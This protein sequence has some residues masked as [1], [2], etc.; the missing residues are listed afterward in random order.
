MEFLT[1]DILDSSWNK[2]YAEYIIRWNA[3]AI[4]YNDISS[5]AKLPD[6]MLKSML[7]KAVRFVPSLRQIKNDDA[8]NLVR[9]FAPLLYV[10]YYTLLPSA[11]QTQDKIRRGKGKRT[12]NATDF[13]KQ[14]DEDEAVAH[15]L[16]PVD[17]RDRPRLPA[18]L[19]RNFSPEDRQLWISFSDAAKQKVVDSLVK[20]KQPAG[21]AFAKR[22]PRRSVN[23]AD[24]NED[25]SPEDDE[26]DDQ[27][28]DVAIAIHQADTKNTSAKD[29]SVAFK[30]AH[31]AD[32]L[33]PLATL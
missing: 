27:E 33:F 12:V 28:E 14:D 13:S 11:C 2:P 32:V 26:E 9:G 25:T 29:R 3:K 23:L 21:R 15:M 31:P 7:Q 16:Y 1:S 6:V 19:F 4:S 20:E 17:R 5:D 10:D 24:V 30:E 8:Q 22:P 18:S